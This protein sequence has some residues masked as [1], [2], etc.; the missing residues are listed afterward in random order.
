M[1]SALTGLDGTTFTSPSFGF[2]IE[3][4]STWSVTGETIAASEELLVL[5]NG[6]S[7][8]TLQATREYRGDLEGCVLFANEQIVDLP[9]FT[10]LAPDLTG[11]GQPFEGSNADAAYANFTYTGSD[12]ETYAHFVSCQ[13]IVDGESYLILTQDVPYDAYA[14]QRQARRQ[15]ENAIV[16]R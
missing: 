2:S 11:S 13:A 16:L 10:D 7:Q 12:G 15:I 5:S 8:I 4:P 6:T 9:A 14:T 1:V 3:I